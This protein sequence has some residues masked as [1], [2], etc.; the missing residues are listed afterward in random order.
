MKIFQLKPICHWW[1]RHCWI[2]TLDL[3]LCKVFLML[4]LPHEGFLCS[5]PCPRRAVI[6]FHW[7][8][9]IVSI[10]WPLAMQGCCIVHPLINA[11]FLCRFTLAQCRVHRSTPCTCR[12]VVVWHQFLAGF[13][14]LTLALTGLFCHPTLAHA[15]FLLFN[16]CPCRFTLMQGSYF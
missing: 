16:P 4:T 9:C 13:P 7:H 6:L 2:A 1:P 12:L 5:N 10:M 14:I 15:G 3:C 8:T 11:R